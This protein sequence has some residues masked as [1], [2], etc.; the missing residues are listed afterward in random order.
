MERSPVDLSYF[1]IEEGEGI[2]AIWGQEGKPAIPLSQGVKCLDLE[3]FLS[4][5]TNS[6]HVKAI[7]D[8]AKMK[9]LTK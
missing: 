6:E 3:K 9:E 2:L 7:K 4:L 1:T 8:W 5:P